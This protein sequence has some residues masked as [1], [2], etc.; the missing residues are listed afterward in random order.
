MKIA[1]IV[2]IILLAVGLAVAIVGLCIGNFK[3]DAEPRT[4]TVE[5]NEDFDRIVVDVDVSD[6]KFV[7]SGTGKS[8]VEIVEYGKHMHH[9]V[10][11][12]NGTLNITME[13]DRDWYEHVGIFNGNMSVT[14]YLARTDLESLN[15]ETD[16]GA[17]TVPAG[18]S[19]KNASVDVDTGMVTWAANVWQKLSVD[20]DTGMISI[21]DVTCEDLKLE[22]DT[23]KVTVEKTKVMRNMSVHVSTGK[24]TLKN[25]VAGGTL[26]IR[27]STGDVSLDA[28]DGGII[29]IKTGTGDVKGT[30]LTD[31][32]F[33]A[34]SGTG[35]VHT[36]PPLRGSG[37]C[38]IYCSTGNINI[39][40]KE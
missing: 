23:G 31:K 20:T 4:N 25:T 15:V 34:Q 29:N 26:D 12:K 3:F 17:V 7:T 11:V 9:D 10:K 8:F 18:I 19:F 24:L 5:L 6:V 16:T 35:D 30:L 32:D 36:P 1:I 27:T 13:D 2:A 38:K 22:S 28:C 37:E 33:D 39:S 40:I 21:S 14:V